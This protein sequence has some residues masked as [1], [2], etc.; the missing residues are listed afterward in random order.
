MCDLRGYQDFRELRKQLALQV[1]LDERRSLLAAFH[2]L[3]WDATGIVPF[4]RFDRLV[5]AYVVAAH[6]SRACVPRVL[7]RTSDAATDTPCWGVRVG[8]G[9]GCGILRMSRTSRCLA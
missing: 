8:G 6:A 9:A 4:D 1:H 5:R 2:L 7:R 3:D